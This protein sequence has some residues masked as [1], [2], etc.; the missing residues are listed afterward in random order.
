MTLRVPVPIG[1]HYVSKRFGKRAG[2]AFATKPGID[3][4]RN[5]NRPAHRKDTEMQLL[6]LLVIVPFIGIALM[7]IV[8]ER[9]EW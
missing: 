4:R 9:K 1:R 2:K 3:L 5:A 6:E 8:G 7:L